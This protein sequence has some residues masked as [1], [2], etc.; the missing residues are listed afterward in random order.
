[1]IYHKGPPPFKGAQARH[2]AGVCHNRSCVNPKHLSW[3]TAA[4]NA[5]DKAVDGTSRNSGRKLTEEQA[6]AIFFDKGS[7][8]DVAERHSV[9]ANYV[10]RLRRKGAWKEEIERAIEARIGK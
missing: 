4:Q 9:S 7:A 5:A 6:L 8:K 10:Y 1:L 3:G 2:K